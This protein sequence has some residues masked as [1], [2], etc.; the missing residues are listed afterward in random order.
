M[1]D[2]GVSSK[3]YND[4]DQRLKKDVTQQIERWKPT[5]Q[6]CV[7]CWRWSSEYG[8]VE[9]YKEILIDPT[10]KKEKVF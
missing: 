4:W 9:P 7:K 8:C 1:G 2:K 3:E 5:V 6:F 10:D